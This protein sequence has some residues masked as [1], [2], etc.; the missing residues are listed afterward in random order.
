MAKESNFKNMVLTLFV[1]CFCGSA[2]L[3]GAYLITQAPIA[4]AQA[5]I[6]NKA[7]SGVLP[8]FDNNPS[9]EVYDMQIE[10]QTAKVYPA[11]L[12]GAKAGIAVEV[13]STRGFGGPIQVLV[14]FFPDGTIC[15]TALI[16]HSETPGLGDKLDQRKSIFSLQF[17]GK[18]PKNFTLAVKKDGGQVDA[19]TAATISSRAF[20]HAIDMAYKVFTEIDLQDG[21]QL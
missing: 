3:G 11:L 18:N 8:V 6:I 21:G 7:L 5:E 2:V 14:G 13:I 9:E 12:N 4:S 10:G 19:I 15:N 17:N 16:S 20:C 1:I